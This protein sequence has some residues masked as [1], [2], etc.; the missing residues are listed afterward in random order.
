MPNPAKLDPML[1]HCAEHVLILLCLKGIYLLLNILMSASACEWAFLTALAWFIIDSHTLTG[2]LHTAETSL[3]QLI[4]QCDE[5]LRLIQDLALRYEFID[6]RCQAANLKHLRARDATIRELNWMAFCR[7][8]LILEHMRGIK[9][10]LRR[11]SS[12][13]ESESISRVQSLT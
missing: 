8:S 7:R 13:S 4:T 2:E 10:A 3:V 12:E 9:L 5:S 11:T 6:R 1:V